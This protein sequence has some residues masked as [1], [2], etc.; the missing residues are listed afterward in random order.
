MKAK[1]IEIFLPTGEPLEVEEATLTTSVLKVIHLNQS[2]LEHIKDRILYNGCYILYGKD[3]NEDEIVYIGE[4]D[5]IFNR[6]KSHKKNKEFW[7]EAYAI[8]H[9]GNRFDKANLH[10]LENIMIKEAISANRYKVTN[11]NN[12][13]ENNTT[14]S[15]AAES[16][17]FF[18]DIKLI[19][20]TLG[21]D[22]FKPKNTKLNVDK[23]NSFYFK[24]NVIG[25]NAEAIYENDELTVLKGSIASLKIQKSNNKVGLQKRLLSEGVLQEKEGM[26]EFSNDY[27]F[28]SPSAAGSIVSGSAVNGWSVWKTKEGKTLDELFRNV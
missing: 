28:K 20:H 14:E 17:N 11:G 13:Q 24:S 12:G 6:L 22:L 9:V 5:N 2:Q 26:L 25:Y 18:E 8:M 7:N 23:N 16:I 1:T 10:Y 3:D 15:K 19:L 27:T 4:A 21:L